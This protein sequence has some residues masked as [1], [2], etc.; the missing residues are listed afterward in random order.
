MP[1]LERGASDQPAH[2]GLRL[3][4]CQYVFKGPLDVPSRLRTSA[5]AVAYLLPSAVGR[6]RIWN[7]T[8][9]GDSDH[10]HYA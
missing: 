5:L 2:S 9:D 4:D 3:S 8:H 6:S 7:D 1:W 10:L